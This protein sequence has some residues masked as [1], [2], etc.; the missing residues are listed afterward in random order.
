MLLGD[1]VVAVDG[2]SVASLQELRAGLS[3]K[4]GQ[5]VRVTVHRGGVPTDLQLT[6]GQWPTEKRRC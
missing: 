1:I 6:A 2:T 3:D 4:V 5:T